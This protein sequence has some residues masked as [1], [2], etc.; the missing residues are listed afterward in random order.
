MDFRPAP[1]Q[2][3]AGLGPVLGLCAFQFGVSFVAGLVFLFLPDGGGSGIGAV[4]SMTGALGYAL[5]AETKSPGSLPPLLTRRLA[6]RA[7][8][9][10][11]LISAPYLLYTIRGFVDGPLDARLAAE[12]G[13][14]FLIVCVVAGPI[15]FLVTWFG[16]AQGRRLAER[17]RRR[18]ADATEP[19]V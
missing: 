18:K 5:W 11:I 2:E 14:G 12:M 7:T 19:R 8:V 9:A 1:G 10:A 13:A 6:F 15:M 17:S 16:L 3:T 4:G